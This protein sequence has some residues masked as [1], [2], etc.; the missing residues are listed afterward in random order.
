M[1]ERLFRAGDP[2]SGSSAA[3]AVGVGSGVLTGGAA[4]VA[5]VDAGACAT[6][7]AGADV[8]LVEIVCACWRLSAV[9]NSS[10]TA[11]SRSSALL[12]CA[13]GGVKINN[14]SFCADAVCACGRRTLAWKRRGSPADRRSCAAYRQRRA[15]RQFR[16]ARRPRQAR[17]R[18]I[19]AT[20]RQAQRHSAPQAQRRAAASATARPARLPAFLHQAPSR[21]PAPRQPV[22]RLPAAR[23]RPAAAAKPVDFPARRRSRRFPAVGTVWAGS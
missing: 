13:V 17:Q 3:C 10:A 23:R 22:R 4:T 15:S 19:A 12:F 7:G 9:A 18:R 6:T 20:R 8:R 16:S 14:D 11:G 2:T 21:R 5:G 1:A